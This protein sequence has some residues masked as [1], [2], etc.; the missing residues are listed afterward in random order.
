MKRIR[1][2][3]DRTAGKNLEAFREYFRL[4]FEAWLDVNWDTYEE[5]MAKIAEAEKKGLKLEPVW[6]PTE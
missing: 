2:T 3:D 6:A 1:V 5:N 4:Q